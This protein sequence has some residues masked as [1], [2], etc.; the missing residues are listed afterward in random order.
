MLDKEVRAILRTIHRT[1]EQE[2][3]E[4]GAAA[5]A[6]QSDAV[7]IAAERRDVVPQPDERRYLVEQAEITRCVVLRAGSQKACKLFEFEVRRFNIAKF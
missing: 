4:N 7:A 6:Q 5:V 1:E 2:V 3:G